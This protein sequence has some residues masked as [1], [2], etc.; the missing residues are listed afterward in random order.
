MVPE[1]VREHLDAALAAAAGDDLVIVLAVTGP[2]LL[3]LSHS[4]GRC[5]W[6]CRVR[7]RR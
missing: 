7:A 2:G 6:A 1:P 3:P 4:R 5:T